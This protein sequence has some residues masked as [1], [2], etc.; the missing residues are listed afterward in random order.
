MPE[1]VQQPQRSQPAG[2]PSNS[3]TGSGRPSIGSHLASGSAAGHG[4]GDRGSAAAAGSGSSGAARRFLSKVLHPVQQHQQQQQQQRALQGSSGAGP[5]TRSLSSEGH[6]RRV[7]TPVSSATPTAA[8][9]SGAY[10][11][12]LVMPGSSELGS[13]TM[14]A[15][16]VSSQDAPLMII[17]TT[18]S[19]SMWPHASGAAAA[20]SATHNSSAENLLPSGVMADVSSPTVGSRGSSRMYSSGPQALGEGR[21]GTTWSAV[22]VGQRPRSSGNSRAATNSSGDLDPMPLW[23]GS[24]VNPGSNPSGEVGEVQP[25][26]RW[27]RRGKRGSSGSTSGGA[28]AGQ[29]SSSGKQRDHAVRVPGQALDSSE[30]EQRQDVQVRGL[31]ISS[32]GMRHV[33]CVC[34]LNV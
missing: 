2:V 5:S 25:A 18:A 32:L 33:H 23:Q 27:F 9:S 14:P 31:N 17:P 1:I 24:F 4:S 8:G 15:S 19:G 12:P 26:V 20:T 28:A 6:Y 34:R 22:L 29:H 16:G 30:D 13:S 21:D 11:G 7:V 3:S 10:Q